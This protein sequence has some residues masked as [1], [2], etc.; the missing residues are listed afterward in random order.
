MDSLSP[1]ILDFLENDTVSLSLFEKYGVLRRFERSMIVL[2]C[3]HQKLNS[4]PY[5]LEDQLKSIYDQNKKIEKEEKEK[6]AIARG[7]FNNFKIGN[8]WKFTIK[9]AYCREV[10]GCVHTDHLIGQ[11]F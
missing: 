8:G 7:N 6:E 2:H 10:S 3:W 5:V 1:V 11:C 9:L 4:K